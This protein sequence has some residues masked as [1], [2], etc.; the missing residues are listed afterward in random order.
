MARAR[1]LKPAFFT[2]DQVA[3]CSPLARLLFAGLWCLADRAGKLRDR[4][5]KIKAELLP[6][7]DAPDADAWLNEL[8][9][10]GLVLR[11][12]GSDG[13]QYLKITGFEKHQNPHPREPASELPEPC[14]AAASREKAL[15]GPADSPFPI[16]H[17]PF[18]QPATEAVAEPGWLAAVA[19]RVGVALGQPKVGL[20][21]PE[22]RQELETSVRRVVELV[23]EDV[24]VEQI[25]H[26]ARQ[27]LG[28]Q[29]SAL[30]GVIGWLDRT[31]DREWRRVGG[32]R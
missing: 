14:T 22:R 11:Y 17:S 6:Y 26:V 27:H 10:A 24:A 2:S 1:N 13:D 29:L 16:P 15:P 18:P 31:P 23:G 5:R 3:S 21:D 7:E 30:T 4:P 8:S 20:G 28:G 9:R 19:D 25:A 32:P 12:T